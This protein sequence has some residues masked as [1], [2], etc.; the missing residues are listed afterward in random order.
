MHAADITLKALGYLLSASQ[1]QE[2]VKEESLVIGGEW[3]VE[4]KDDLLYITPYKA[5]D[6]PKEFK[7]LCRVLKIPSKIRP[8]LFEEGI[9]PSQIAVLF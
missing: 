5:V 9:D 4:I 1:R 7:E 8:Y 2:I 3:V 6:M